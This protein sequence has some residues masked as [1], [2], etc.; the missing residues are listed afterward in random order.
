MKFH[1]TIWGI[2]SVK[3]ANISLK[4][5]GVKGRGYPF[6]YGADYVYNETPIMLVSGEQTII[7]VQGFLNCILGHI[8]HVISVPPGNW[9]RVFPNSLQVDIYGIDSPHYK[10]KQ[11]L[12][13]PG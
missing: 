2:P 9:H 6:G 3:R 7:I 10:N 5:I 13:L 8:N 4:Y 12:L 11:G 1:S